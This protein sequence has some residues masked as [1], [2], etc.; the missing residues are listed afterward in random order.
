MSDA[1]SVLNGLTVVDLSTGR[2]AALASMF[3]ADNGA[4]VVRVA[5]RDEDVVREP[6]IFA[7]YDRGKEVALL[8]PRSDSET[9]REMCDGADVVLED[10]P[11]SSNLRDALGLDVLTSR[12]PRTVHCSITAYG[13][14]AAHSRTNRLITT[15]SRP[16]WESCRG[17]TENPSTSCILWRTSARGC[18][19]RRASSP[20]SSN[21]SAP[22]TADALRPR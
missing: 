4:R 1:H 22:V 21:G 12:S 17:C 18:W 20:S 14:D 9:I 11:P 2:A 19:R 6:D 15:S 3:L 7:V 16:G 8:D 10:L 5:W 13:T